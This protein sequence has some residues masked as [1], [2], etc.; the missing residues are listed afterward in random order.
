M[1]MIFEIIFTKL[2]NLILFDDEILFKPRYHKIKIFSYE[3]KIIKTS[4]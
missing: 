4:Y 2:F 3:S 1:K